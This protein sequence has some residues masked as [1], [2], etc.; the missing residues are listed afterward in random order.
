M[1][2]RQDLQRQL[3]KGVSQLKLDVSAEKL[4]QLLDYI[5]LFDKWN[6]AYNLSAVRE[7]SE[8]VSRHLLDS[9][10][11]MTHVEQYFA[12]TNAER[13]I[14]VG[15]G[16]GLPGIPLAIFFPESLLL[17]WI[18]TARKRAFCFR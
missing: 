10:A 4:S 7:I 1:A 18:Q 15:T 5:E 6:R 3:E 8:M 9:L 17:Y 11:V 2:S 12:T 16:G 13:F 14:D